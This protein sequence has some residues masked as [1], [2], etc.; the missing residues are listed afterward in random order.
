V[1]PVRFDRFSP[2]F[3]SATHYQLQLVPYDY[4]SLI[5]PFANHA[6][7]NMAYYFRDANVNAQYASDAAD[8]LTALSNI[9]SRWQGLWANQPAPPDLSWNR[10][11]EPLAIHDSRSSRVVTH[12]F[13]DEECRTLAALAQPM[14]MEP[15]SADSKSIARPEAARLLFE[16]R[17]RAMSLVLPDEGAT[18]SLHP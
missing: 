4:Y 9:V 1:F 13:S 17:G 12:R 6:L 2:Y 16:E 14:R 3:T 8:W 15:G 5:Y 7:M 18:Q 11:E 10:P